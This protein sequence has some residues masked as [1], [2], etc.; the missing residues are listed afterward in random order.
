MGLWAFGAVPLGP[1]TLVMETVDEKMM[2]M[3]TRETSPLL[4]RW[5]HR[6]VVAPAGS[7]QTLYSDTVELDAGPLTPVVGAVARL[8]F[9]HRHRR[10]H[11]L[12]KELARAPSL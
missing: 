12:A 6:I 9:R 1:H 2:T 11:A 8:F 4:R 5:D 7:G 10:W 3:Q